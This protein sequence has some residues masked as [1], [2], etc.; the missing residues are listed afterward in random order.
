MSAVQFRLGILIRKVCV[1]KKTKR[2]MK[3]NH[4]PREGFGTISIYL[5]SRFLENEED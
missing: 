4:S 5:L 2:T 3:K 1:K